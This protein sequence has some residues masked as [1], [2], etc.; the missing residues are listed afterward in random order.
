MPVADEDV[1]WTEGGSEADNPRLRVS[2]RFVRLAL[3]FGALAIAWSYVALLDEVSTGT[4][5][6]VPTMQEQVIQ[7]LEGGVLARLHV[8]QDDVVEPGQILAQ[9][10]PTV[11][12]S[13]V[14][15][16]AAKYRA[17]LASAARL[18]AEVNRTAL[19][20]PVE[21]D[22]YPS[23]RAAETELFEARRKSLSETLQWID[24]SA[25][26]VR[27]ELAI[28]QSLTAMGAASNVE[29]IRLKRQ[30]V[31][32][33][34]KQT[35]VQSDYVVRA[36]EELAKANAEVES[37][38][39][40]VKGRADSLS[41][42]TLRSPVRG[43]VKNIEVY[44]I[45]GVVPPNG[46][47]MDIVPLDEQLLIEARIFPRDIAYIHPD[48]R[49]NVKISAYDY[50]IYGGLT[51]RVTSISPD[52]IQDEIKP[53]DYYYRV[54]IRTESDALS[55]ARGDRFPIV[56]GMVAT[57]DI[58]TGSKTVFDYLVKPLNRGREAMRER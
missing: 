8:R 43:I 57:V 14:E 34:L 4:G 35:E 58:H 45:G 46:K 7:S 2:K 24:E 19:S 53:D 38:S 36:R 37:L 20:F 50:A 31:E 15:E 1:Q 6:V 41:R 26:L 54:F 17:A 42:L 12:Q 23:L 13:S 52:T 47:L 56:P 5:K 30:L 27:D 9:L 33:Q 28:N 3:L 21:L 18:T 16:S 51:G 55:N 32:L 39:S 10:D 48:Q 40:V 49:A 44:T 29:V 25:R 22:D 11:T